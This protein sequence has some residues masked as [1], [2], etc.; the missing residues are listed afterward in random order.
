[1][2]FSLGFRTRQ[3]HKVLLLLFNIIL[4]VLPIIKK[5]RKTKDLNTEKEFRE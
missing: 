5:P 4:E 3:A 1:M 2:A